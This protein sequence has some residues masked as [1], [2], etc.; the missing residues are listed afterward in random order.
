MLQNTI[1]GL[2]ALRSSA[3]RPRL[4]SAPG[5][6]PS[7]TASAVFASSRKT[8]WASGVRQV[9]H[10]RSLAPVD[11]EVHEGDALDDRPGHAADVVAGR[12]LDL[13]DFSSE[14]DQVRGEGARAEDRTLDDADSCGGLAWPWMGSPDRST[15][16][17]GP[18]DSRW[19]PDRPTDAAVGQAPPRP[20]RTPVP[21]SGGD[22]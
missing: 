12:R 19:R 20:G 17:D 11:V 7:M 18:S 16:S 5:R 2:I 6:M 15:V 14:I 4:A 3:A 22:A 10:Q 1:F 21:R 8:S 9:E 13:D